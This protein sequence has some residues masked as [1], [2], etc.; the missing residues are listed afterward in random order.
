MKLKLNPDRGDGGPGPIFSEVAR[1]SMTQ[2]LSQDH[3]VLDYLEQT[4]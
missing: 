1:E 3:S 4:I 2:S